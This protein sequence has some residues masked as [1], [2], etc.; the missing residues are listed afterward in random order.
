MYLTRHNIIS[1]YISLMLSDDTLR[2]LETEFCGCSLLPA[3]SSQTHLFIVT[4]EQ[5]FKI[6]GYVI[7][8]SWAAVL[9]RLSVFLDVALLRFLVGFLNFGTICQP[10]LSKVKLDPRI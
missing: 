9:F 2:S 5:I 6:C 4:L 7:L 1:D 8:R 10:H 3:L